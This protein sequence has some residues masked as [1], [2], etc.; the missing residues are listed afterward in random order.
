MNN[1][2]GSM[3]I[4]ERA[5]VM[6]AQADTIQK[7]K[8]LKSLALTAA[9]W[10]KRKGMGEAAIQHCR[11]YALEAERKMG[12]MLVATE[13]AKA[14]RPAKLV[15]AGDQFSEPTLSDLGLTK[16]ESAEAQRLAAAP[17]EDFEAVIAGKMTRGDLRRKEK[18]R[19][20]EAKVIAAGKGRR[21][22]VAGPFDLILADPPWRYEHCEAN[23]REIE[24]Q[25]PT[26][27]LEE[28]CADKPD[29]ANDSILFLWATAPKL[30]EALLVMRE[31]GYSYRSCAVWDKE[32]IGMGY[33]WRIQHEL[34]LV[35]I[36]GNPGATPESERVS[37]IFKSRRGRHSQKPQ[38]IYEWI[39]RS[40][41]TLKKQER[42]A[43]TVR[44]G[45]ASHGNEC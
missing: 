17:G 11:S 6:L 35:G 30:D 18:R 31:W 36:R 33:W 16:R 4:F 45:W 41:P 26:M 34:L 7:A 20:H 37:S 24:N 12:E 1:E 27:T 43:R 25:Y 8:E 19:Q 39:E 15:T 21:E 28:I 22:I 29:G 38:I 40:F 3:V 13:R 14:G 5:A 32:V 23:N 42:Y 44:A 9:D 2:N 10:A